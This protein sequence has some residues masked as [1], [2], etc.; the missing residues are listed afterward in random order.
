M[1][2]TPGSS[3]FPQSQSSEHLITIGKVWEGEYSWPR[4]DSGW[5]KWELT[6]PEKAQV[7]TGEDAE[8]KTKAPG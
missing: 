4:L 8:K 7:I 5:R 1:L 6:A 3:A 2:P